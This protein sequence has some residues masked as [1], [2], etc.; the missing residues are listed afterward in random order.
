MYPN[1][2]LAT[3]AGLFLVFIFCCK[4]ESP[5]LL[6][7]PDYFPPLPISDDNPLTQAKIDLGKQLFSDKSLS[8]DSTIMCGSCHKLEFALAD[9][10]AISPGVDGRRGK[11]NSPSLINAAF[12]TLVNKDGG[13]SKLDIQALIP[14]EDHEEMGISIIELTSRLD[15][16]KEYDALFTHA[17]GRKADGYTIPRAFAS[18]VR[19][20]VDDSTLYDE[21]LKGDTTA[22]SDTAIRG[23][24]LFFSDALA[25]G[26][27]HTGG[28]LTNFEFE[29]NGLYADYKDLGRALITLQTSDQGKFRIPSLRNVT[30][31]S[32]YMHDGSV[33]S[34]E[35][36]IEHYASGGSLHPNKSELING[37]KISPDEM[38]DLMSFLESLTSQDLDQ[39][40]D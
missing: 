27:C 8:I 1:S 4:Q 35:D 31:T 6:S 18:Y 2:K 20:L 12:T 11:R 3:V 36:V 23:M 16:H 30:L 13:V 7:Y 9:S 38:T 40:L 26:T 28:L 10:V 21:Y 37:F 33:A 15:G 17:F 5:I 22:L 25:C 19:S 39:F 32:P 29:N 14:I 24:K 34:L